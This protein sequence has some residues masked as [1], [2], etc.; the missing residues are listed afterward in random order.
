MGK[1][2]CNPC[3]DMGFYQYLENEE[4]YGGGVNEKN[5]SG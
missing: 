1:S 4:A 2:A 3:Y 5:I